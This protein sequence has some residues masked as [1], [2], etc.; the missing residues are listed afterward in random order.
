[1]FIRI[2]TDILYN[3]P[4]NTKGV[5]EGWMDECMNGQIDIYLYMLMD[6]K[7]VFYIYLYACG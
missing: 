4:K 6:T 3:I 1:M 5:S 2:S 7:T